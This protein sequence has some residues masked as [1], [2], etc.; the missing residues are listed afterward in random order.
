[1]E[2]GSITTPEHMIAQRCI[3]G[4][5]PAGMMLG[6][7]LARQGIDTVVLEKHGDF[8]RDFR[9]D[10]MHPST[11]E[12][13]HELG[14]LDSLL[15]LPH[16][17][18]DRVRAWVD[19]DIV[20]FADFTHLPTRCRYGTMLPQWDFLSFVAR[21]G[22]S[23]PSFR[24]QMDASVDD[25]VIEGG[26]VVGATATTPSGPIKVHSDLVVGADGRTSTVRQRAGLEVK[27]VGAPVD[28]LWFR[29]S[30]RP[31][32]PDDAHLRIQSGRF[33]V[34]IAR[35]DHWQC[36][37]VIAKGTG[38]ATRSRGLEALRAEI[39]DSVP[40][41]A[42]RVHELASWDDLPQLTV[43]V[44]RLH[45][46]YRDGLLCIGDAAHAMSPAGGIGINLAIQDAVATANILGAPL[47]AGRPSTADLRRVQRRRSWAARATQ[48][49][50]VAITNRTLVPALAG[51]TNPVRLPAR[52]LRRVPA[53]A[54]IPGR[55]IGIGLRP[56]HVQ[57]LRTV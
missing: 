50:Q 8:L 51:T 5:G 7:L 37:Y 55:A 39:A 27:D 49:A 40:F 47:R 2:V 6:Y 14:L 15:E 30:R 9:G 1:M 18:I 13:M 22:R 33:I 41:L 19:D 54:R 42:D 35:P 3:A 26:R 56:E 45:R 38:D 21:Q 24:L 36:G 4:G 29:L 32:D 48:R 57:H 23:L 25:L 44:D 46:W 12:V 43:R 17:R 52:A 53:L 34:L 20:T 31:A 11:L 28:V 16:H 10:S